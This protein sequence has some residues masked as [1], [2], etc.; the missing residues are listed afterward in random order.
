MLAFDSI[1]HKHYQRL[2]PNTFQVPTL[3]HN[4]PLPINTY[5]RKAYI[6]EEVNTHFNNYCFE[7]PGDGF[8]FTK[9]ATMFTKTLPRFWGTFPKEGAGWSFPCQGFSLAPL[10][11]SLISTTSRVS[12]FLTIERGILETDR[13]AS[14]SVMFY[15]FI[16]I[17]FNLLPY[18]NLFIYF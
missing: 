14:I 16:A 5:N 6:H 10:G 2:N 3:K 9:S 8:P 11:F 17:G 4:K 13:C 12:L 1:L 15:L 7:E 18:F